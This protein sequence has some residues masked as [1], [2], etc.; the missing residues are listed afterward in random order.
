M[1]PRTI[2]GI[3]FLIHS[4]SHY[5]VAARDDDSVIASAHLRFDGEWWTLHVAMKA[6]HTVTRD[7]RSLADAMSLLSSRRAA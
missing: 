5:Q 4:P 7:F 6:G 3:P 1:I 2:S